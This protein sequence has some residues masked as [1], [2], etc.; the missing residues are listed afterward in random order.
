MK[1]AK[2]QFGCFGCIYL[3]LFLIFTPLSILRSCREYRETTRGV[4]FAN[5]SNFVICEQFG[6]RNSNLYKIKSIEAYSVS[7]E[8]PSA[9][10]AKSPNIVIHNEDQS[11][12]ISFPSNI[13]AH[14]YKSGFFDTDRGAR[15]FEEDIEQYFANPSQQE[16]VLWDRNN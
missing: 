9:R 2:R 10:S 5:E 12:Y 11:E 4:C 15:K 3:V 6:T 1:E 7:I 16:L 14:S 13:A 8:Y